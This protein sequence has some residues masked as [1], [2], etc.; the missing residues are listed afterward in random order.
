VLLFA[1]DGLAGMRDAVKRQFPEAEHQQC[2]V[3]LSRTV[4]RYIRNK[5]RKNV[6][7]DLKSV[8]RATSENEVRKA[9]AEFLAKYGKCYPKLAGIFERAEESLYPFYKFSEAIRK[10]IYTTNMIERSNKGLKHKSKVK[11]QFPNEDVLEC[12]VCCYYCDL[13]RSYSKR[14]QRGFCQASAEILQLFEDRL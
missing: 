6:L 11:E 14:M 4:A 5:D 10:S 8:Y 7:D 13:N 2:W 1:S 3:Y 9:L 12:F